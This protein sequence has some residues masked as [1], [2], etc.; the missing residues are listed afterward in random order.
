MATTVRTT[1]ARWARA[2]VALF[3]VGLAFIAI[4]V[5]PFFA[6]DHNT[7]LWLNLACLLAP[8]GFAITVWSGVRGGRA[9]QRAAAQRTHGE[10]P[11]H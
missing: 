5:L 8:L 9:D 7:S 3:V 6:G 4:D 1:T 2:G 10:R 11:I